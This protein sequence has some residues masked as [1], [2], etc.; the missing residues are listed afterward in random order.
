MKKTYN[1][2]TAKEIVSL[3][4]CP[5][6]CEGLCCKSG[7]LHFYTKKEYNNFK[8]IGEGNNFEKIKLNH[9]TPSNI[10]NTYTMDLPCAF[11]TEDGKCKE[12]D[13]VNLSTACKLFPF[14]PL[15]QSGV[16]SMNLYLCPLGMKIFDV[17]I[18]Q[19][20]ELGLKQGLSAEFIELFLNDYYSKKAEV[21]QQKGKHYK[22]TTNIN[23]MQLDGLLTIIKESNEVKQ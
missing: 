5:D 4:D 6:D 3:F 22:P 13:N 9:S 20:L 23:P 15:N 8:N 1:I 17:I 16:I 21:E 12:H 11:L 2:E 7:K 19:R 18:K 10:V 14:A